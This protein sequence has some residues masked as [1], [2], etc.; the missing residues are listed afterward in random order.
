MPCPKSGWDACR[1]FGGLPGPVVRCGDRGAGPA[2]L[3]FRSRP[4]VRDW[5]P[6]RLNQVLRQEDEVGYIV[7]DALDE[8][9][10]LA[11]RIRQLLICSRHAWSGCTGWLR[12]IAHRHARTRDPAGFLRG[13]AAAHRSR[14]PKH[15]E[16]IVLDLRRFIAKR[17]TTNLQER[18]SQAQLIPERPSKSSSR[19]SERNFLDVTQA[20]PGLS[21]TTAASTA[22]PV[23]AGLDRLFQAFLKHNFPQQSISRRAHR[24]EVMIA[25]KSPP[26]EEFDRSGPVCTP[27]TNC[28]S[29]A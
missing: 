16:D 12:L 15:V 11:V 7:I 28:P 24:V 29:A 14:Q 5:R 4:R 18:L 1:N 3:R 8:S 17:R 9:L 10:G 20:P 26:T 13:A 23:A 2:E 27:R 6:R 25:R 21:G 19:K 22:R